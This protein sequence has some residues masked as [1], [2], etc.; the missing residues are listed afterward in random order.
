MIKSRTL[1]DNRFVCAR[2]VH[3]RYSAPAYCC[4]I[5]GEQ[6]PDP[7]LITITTCDRFKSKEVKENGSEGRIQPGS[8]AG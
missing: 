6:V 4:N 3:L 2:C 5:D 7:G 1:T 8:E